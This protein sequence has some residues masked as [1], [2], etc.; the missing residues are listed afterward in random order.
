MIVD[1][2]INELIGAIDSPDG[3]SLEELMLPVGRAA[4]GIVDP[5]GG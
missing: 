5:D 1:C 2:G 3:T 4:D